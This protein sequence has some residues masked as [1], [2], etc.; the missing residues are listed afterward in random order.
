MSEV[1]LSKSGFKKAESN[2]DIFIWAKAEDGI[3]SRHPM[4]GDVGM[5]PYLFRSNF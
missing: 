1:E 3:G 2:Y 5:S 4:L